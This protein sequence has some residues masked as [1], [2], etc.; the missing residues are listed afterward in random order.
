MSV[1]YVGE[2]TLLNFNA[3]KIKGGIFFNFP[4]NSNNKEG[5]IDLMRE[6]IK[7]SFL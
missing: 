3:D 5:Y 1:F 4:A 7:E 2:S 6:K